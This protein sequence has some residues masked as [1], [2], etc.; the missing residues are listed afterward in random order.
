MP[1]GSAQAP[2]DSE[3]HAEASIALP[4]KNLKDMN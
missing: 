1:D 2:I 4:S 3:R